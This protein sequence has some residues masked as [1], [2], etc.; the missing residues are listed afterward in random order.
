MFEA[1]IEPETPFRSVNSGQ[2]RDAI[3]R[4]TVVPDLDGACLNQ[5]RELLLLV[6]GGQPSRVT[7]RAAR[8]AAANQR[9]RLVREGGQWTSQAL[10]SSAG[11]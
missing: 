1:V 3:S 4:R 9:D 5:R 7:R 2:V 6:R 11:S 8:M 10:M